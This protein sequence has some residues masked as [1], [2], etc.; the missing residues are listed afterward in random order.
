VPSKDVLKK[1]FSDQTLMNLALNYD[2]NLTARVRE[3]VSYHTNDI[4]GVRISKDYRKS[5]QRMK[6]RR[7][8]YV[9]SIGFILSKRILKC[10]L[11]CLRRKQN[12]LQNSLT[13]YPDYTLN[14][15]ATPL[16]KELH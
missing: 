11:C 15:V 1:K 10:H 3:V 16:N 9:T 6:K 8:A 12:S 4:M 13:V 2:K 14:E 7:K 5:F